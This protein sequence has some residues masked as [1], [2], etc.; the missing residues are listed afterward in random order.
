MSAKVLSESLSNGHSLPQ[1][2]L[3]ELT[4]NL[5][6]SLG[7]VLFASHGVQMAKKSEAEDLRNEILSFRS[8]SRSEKFSEFYYDLHL[9]PAE[10]VEEDDDK[11]LLDVCS[12]V[13]RLKYGNDEELEQALF[14]LN[15]LI[16]E[17]NVAKEEEEEIIP[18]LFNRLNSSTSNNRSNIIHTLR[19]LVD[20][21]NDIKGKMGDI[22]FLSTLVKSLFGDKDEQREAIMLLSTLSDIA[23]V[24]RR[25]GRIPGFIVMLVAIFNGDDA[26]ASNDAG[27][28]LDSLATN[29]QY[30][31]HI[32][33]A[34]YFK[35]LVRYLKEGSDMRNRVQVATA[36][37][38]MTL[39]D[40]SRALLGEDGA[41]ESLVKM[42][43]KGN[44]ESKQSALSALQNL[45]GLKANVERLVNSGVVLTL[46]QLL[47]SVTSILMTL[48]EPASAILARIA[49][50][51]GGLLVK[52]D[53]AQKM[54]SLLNLTSPVIQCHLLEA[55][56]SITSHSDGSNVRRRMNENGA[57]RLLLPFL[58][59]TYPKIRTGALRLIHILLSENMHGEMMMTEQLD[60]SHVHIIAKIFSDSSSSVEEK[61]SAVGIL[62]SFPYAIINE[63]LL[64]GL[65]SLISSS[66][67]TSPAISSNMAE[68][69]AGALIPLTHPSDR[70]CQHYVAEQ[71]AI[72]A[73]VN[74][75]SC[76]STLAKHRSAICLAQ[77]SQTSLAL[78]KSRKQRWFCGMPSVEGFCQVH[79]SHC[80][81]RSTFCIVMAGAIT[82]LLQI[83]QGGER[84]ADESVLSCIATL[85]EDEI[86]EKGCDYLVKKRGVPSLIKVLE[87]GSAVAQEKSV[88]ILERVFRVEAYIMEHGESAKPLLVDLA[89]NGHA[90]LKLKAAK[91]LARLERY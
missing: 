18:I 69:I 42:F 28:L 33:E 44:F 1:K 88:W 78:R 55:L 25:L 31:I 3:D 48:R 51:E 26:A 59:E 90:T 84:G 35:P 22:R 45:Y 36:L 39:T 85:V 50:S 46:L 37:S 52:P 12:L 71:G 53:I 14:G 49:Q 66:P 5:E 40:K 82:P 15:L 20:Q 58:V 63:N 38:R 11:T 21:N 75:L 8:N 89:H 4:E 41:V 29:I 34:G 2:L 16:T 64:P 32:A 7:F 60:E 74:L 76:D 10:F 91:L 67:N 56:N 73:L 77:L 87:A 57:I 86:W 54:L 23:V 6:R 30:A 70:K 9:S 79:D 81:V 43:S 17:S 80:S 24:R 72:P 19:R 68:N 62:S 61:A 65:I 13:L 47:F 83:L 27:N